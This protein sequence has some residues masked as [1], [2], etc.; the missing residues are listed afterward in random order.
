MSQAQDVGGVAGEHLRAFIE[1][2]E[3]L[4]A[5]K[6]DLANDIKEVYAEAKGT[7]FDVKIIRKLISM[8]KQ[9]SEKRQEE[10]EL[11]SLYKQAIGL[12]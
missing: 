6:A 9:D 5:E 12:E 3:R 4:E 8:R 2:I 11:L 1:R 7:G 10:E